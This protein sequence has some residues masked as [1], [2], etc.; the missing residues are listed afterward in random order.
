MKRVIFVAVVVAAIAGIAYLATLGCCQVLG[1]TRRSRSLTQGLGLNAGQ[2]Q[3][4]AALEKEYLA[5]KQASCGT[6]CAKRAQLIQLLKQEKP[7]PGVL[8]GLVEEIGREQLALE[9]ATLD[10]LLA[11]NRTLEPAQRER[12]VASV[13]EELRLAC[14][15]TACGAAGHCF[16]AEAVRSEER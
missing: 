16:V 14:K 10:H 8:N 4:V 7:D 5:R 1:I 13:T 11:V 3:E 9:K 15:A 12:L 6:L 2:R